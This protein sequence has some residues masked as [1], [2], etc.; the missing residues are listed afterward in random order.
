[1]A[2]YARIENGIVQEVIV[3]SQETIDSW[4]FGNPVNWIQTSYNTYGNQH[5]LGGT[6][7]RKNYAGTGF[8][9]N[10][11]LDA[12]IPPCPCLGWLLNEETCLWEPP[13]PKPEDDKFYIWDETLQNWTTE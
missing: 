4:L 13:I 5:A 3:A 8:T 2:H 9:Y 11:E 12:F 7:L 10:S 1:M 6:P